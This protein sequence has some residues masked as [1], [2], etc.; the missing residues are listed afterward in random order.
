MTPLSHSTLTAGREP[1]TLPDD[2]FSEAVLT[3]PFAFH[4]DLREA[5]PLVYLPRYKVYAIGRFAEVRAALVDWQGF[6]SGNGVGMFNPRHETPYRRPQSAMLELDPPFHDAPRHALEPLLGP[7]M[8]TRFREQWTDIAER[9]VDDLLARGTV[10]AISDLAEA[11]PLKVFP[12]AVG[13]PAE[14]RE[15]LLV[16][17]D[18]L[19]NSF[20]PNNAL[21]ESGR[22]AFTGLMQWMAP[23]G[24]RDRLGPG[25]FGADIWAKT[26][27]GDLSAGQAAGLVRSLL[28]AGIDTTVHA[29]GAIMDAFLS[30]P[31]QWQTLR[32]EPQR[33]RVAFDEAIRWGSPVQTLFRTA[34]HDVPVGDMRVPEGEKIMM[35]LAAANR[36][37]RRWDNPH[38]FDLN[39]DPSGHVGFGMGIHRCIGQHVARLEAEIVLHAL[40]RRVARIEPAGAPTPHLNN[41]LRGWKTLPVRLVAA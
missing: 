30:A 37:P 19:F 12:D 6:Q 11:F 33:A 10:D 22:S 23:Q 17:S 2:P 41:T 1:P 7:R 39:R 32:A 36:D 28:V 5:G 35:V 31:A 34:T 40:A 3:N 14:G 38:Q 24:N 27:H 4:H 21:V 15:R 20:G 18:H 13:I 16:Y 26:D 8:L 29:L 9:L 25:G